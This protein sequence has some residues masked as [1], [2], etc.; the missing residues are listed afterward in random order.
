MPAYWL[1]SYYELH[2]GPFAVPPFL[3]KTLE[4]TGLA[5]GVDSESFR[6]KFSPGF[7]E[8]VGK[9]VD[10]EAFFQEETTY[11]FSVSLLFLSAVLQ[12]YFLVPGS[13]TRKYVIKM[14]Q[15]SWLLQEM[16]SAL[17]KDP[18]GKKDFLQE[19]LSKLSLEAEQWRKRNRVLEASS[20]LVLSF[21]ERMQAGGGLLES[22]LRPVQDNDSSSYE[23]L[24]NLV[25]RLQKSDELQKEMCHL[26]HEMIGLGQE[27]DFFQFA[28]SW[29]LLF[30]IRAALKIARRWLNL[31]FKLRK[32]E[33]QEKGDL[34]S[35]NL[36]QV[37]QRAKEAV[38]KY[39][40]DKKDDPLLAASLAVLQ[41]C[42][43]LLEQ[44]PASPQ[45]AAATGGEARGLGLPENISFLGGLKGKPGKEKVER[46]GKALLAL[47]ESQLQDV[48]GHSKAYE[49]ALLPL[50]RS[51]LP[52]SSELQKAGVLTPEEKS[53]LRDILENMD[54]SC[55]KDDPREG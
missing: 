17:L 19:Q 21:W 42:F 36:Q 15:S 24:N 3:I 10:W 34:S 14:A 33:N 7:A 8:E 27:G 30:R 40:A 44:L 37:I 11:N 13:G 51:A 29:Q 22:I 20:P 23:E 39:A 28:G 55:S 16:C 6:E 48:P 49:E 12:L 2:Y 35:S 26:F 46:I 54:N 4:L 9:R 38:E 41:R 31:Q 45:V 52:C 32:V 1:A 47:L 53:F 25:S 50:Y 18:A 5:P 43:S